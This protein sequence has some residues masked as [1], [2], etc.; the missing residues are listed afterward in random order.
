[1]YKRVFKVLLVCFFSVF[2]YI[3]GTAQ[4]N[5]GYNIK[6]TIKPFTTGKCYLAHYYLNDKNY[7]LVDSADVNNKSTVIFKSATT[8]K[9]GI[10]VIGF[11]NKAGLIQVLIDKQQSFAVV[12]NSANPN[13]AVYTNSKVNTDYIAYQ[14]FVSTRGIKLDSLKKEYDKL[15]DK[16]KSQPLITRSETLTKEIDKYR[17]EYIKKESTTVLALLL[18]AAKYPTIPQA[19]QHPKA[20]YD[21]AWAR[22]YYVSNYWAGVDFADDRLLRTPFFEQKLNNF[23]TNVIIDGDSVFKYIDLMLL[24]SK[25]NNDMFKYYINKF[26]AD[27]F[28]PKYG[29]QEKVFV[30]L[31]EKYYNNIKYDWL[32]PANEKIIREKAYTTMANLVG[33]FAYNFT[34]TDINNKPTTLYNIKANYTILCFWDPTC[35]HC[36]TIVPQLDSFYLNKWQS[37]NIKVIGIMVNNETKEW[38]K[39]IADKKLNTWMHLYR[40]PEILKTEKEQGTD[41]RTLYDAYTTPR[42]FLLD[43]EKRI[44][45]RAIEPPQLDTILQYKIFG[46]IKN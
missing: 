31:Y 24:Y 10:Y 9:Q 23:F 13:S 25:H 17:D 5:V 14:N 42:I 27:Y 16:S 26:T 44:I 34:L 6:A 30:K 19:S 39:F 20:K 4:N 12:L 2:L 37:Y 38:E 43:T 22:N 1:M 7:V 36:K 3:N 35:G 32:T 28:S 21:T 46:K 15:A 18:Q 8:L 29:G 45:A 41:L 40:N 11:P 33:D